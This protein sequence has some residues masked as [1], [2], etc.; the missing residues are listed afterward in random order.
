MLLSGG[1]RSP[2]ESI[3]HGGAPE[4]QLGCFGLLV[5]DLSCFLY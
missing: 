4:K 1:S 3:G 2:L 5:G